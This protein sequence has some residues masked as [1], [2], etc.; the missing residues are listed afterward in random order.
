M[1]C[2]NPNDCHTV[3]ERHWD[4]LVVPKEGDVWGYKMGCDPAIYPHVLR[5][6]AHYF[7]S[8]LPKLVAVS[9]LLRAWESAE[10]MFPEMVGAIKEDVRLGTSEEEIAA[11]KWADID[12]I[13]GSYDAQAWDYLQAAPQLMMDVGNDV[14]TISQDSALA[15]GPGNFAHVVS[16]F[17]HIDVAGFIAQ[18]RLGFTGDDRWPT[19][20]GSGA[21][22]LAS[23]DPANGKIKQLQQFPAI[24]T[25]A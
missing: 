12:A 10:W 19:R 16:H 25:A 9:P 13:P 11:G 2:F 7:G 14:F 17:G 6:R 4:R 18:E 23:F 8:V 15:A 3:L 20:M 21:F 22:L 5:T 24:R 1:L